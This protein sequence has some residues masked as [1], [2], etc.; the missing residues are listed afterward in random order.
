MPAAE[1]ELGA[2]AELCP[3]VLQPPRQKKPEAVARALVAKEIARIAYHV[4]RKQEDF[5]GRFKGRVLG[6]TK[7]EQWPLL[8]S[9]AGLTGADAETPQESS[10]SPSAGMGSG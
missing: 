8:A 6:R 2:A 5:N 4:L 10:Q 7:K 3:S 9:P 1:C